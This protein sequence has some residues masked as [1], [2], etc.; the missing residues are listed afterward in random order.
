MS[1]KIKKWNDYLN[2][3]FDQS[4][5]NM[6][7]TTAV[8]NKYKNRVVSTIDKE[9]LDESSENFEKFIDGLPD[10]EKEASDL[11]RSL[12]NSESLETQKQQIQEELQARIK[13]LKD[14][15]SNLP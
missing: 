5:D 3:D 2:E 14:I 9:N 15:Q 12:F 8:Y 13:E 7:N 1:N 4:L 6:K 10:N 11:L